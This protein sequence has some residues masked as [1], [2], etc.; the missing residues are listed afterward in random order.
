MSGY[1]AKAD[2]GASV[3]VS[4]ADVLLY[5]E[6]LTIADRENRDGS[7]G[8]YDNAEYEKAIR[9]MGLSDRANHYLWM[10]NHTSDKYEPEW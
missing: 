3:G 8:S 10:L 7:T 4:T 2:E 5:R 9:R 1:M 6:F